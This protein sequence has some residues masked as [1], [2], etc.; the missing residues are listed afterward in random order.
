VKEIEGN[1]SILLGVER[2]EKP[3]NLVARFHCEWSKK[4]NFCNLPKMNSQG[5]FIINGFDK[6]VVFQSVRAP[7]VYFFPEEKGRFYGEIIP[8]K[9]P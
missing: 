1:L 5:N 3:E 9:G 7:G 8:Y 4:E 6:V 2:G